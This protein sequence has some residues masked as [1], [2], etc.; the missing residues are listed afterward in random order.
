MSVKDN[1]CNDLKKLDGDIQDCVHLRG[2]L[3]DAT[4]AAAI[5]TRFHMDEIELLY[6]EIYKTAKEGFFFLRNTHLPKEHRWAK[7]LTNGAKASLEANGYKILIGD[8]KWII[9][10]GTDEQ[11]EMGHEIFNK[12]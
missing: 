5:A 4:S 2:G 6:V 7:Y 3:I 8:T 9:T 10:W 12:N 11:L 1:R